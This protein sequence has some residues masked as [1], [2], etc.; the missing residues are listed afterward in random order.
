M[1]H[2]TFTFEFTIPYVRNSPRHMTYD[3]ALSLIN[4]CTKHTFCL[5]DRAAVKFTATRTIRGQTKRRIETTL[6]NDVARLQKLERK[7]IRLVRFAPQ[8]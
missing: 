8:E 7:G 6:R 4:Q 5:G 3:E 2:R 1:Q